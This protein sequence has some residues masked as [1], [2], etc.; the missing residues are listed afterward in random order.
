MAIEAR[1]KKGDNALKNKD[2]L[3]A[4]QEFTAA[5]KEN[6]ESFAPFL[7][8]SSAYQKLSNYEKAKEDISTAFTI[9]NQRGKRTEIGLCYFRLGLIYYLEKKFKMAL[10]Q[11]EKATEYDCQEKTLAMWKNKA[12]YDVKKHPEEEEDDLVGDLE[13]D[14]DYNETAAED[15]KT[16]HSTPINVPEGKSAP[17]TVPKPKVD[18]SDKPSTSIDVINKLA[19]LNIKIREDWYQSNDEVIITIYAK[20]VKEEKLKVDFEK[21]A[22]SIS[23]PSG[24]NS[25]YNY[26]LDPLFD[27]IDPE[28]SKYKIFS[29][30][31]EIQLKKKE[32][33]K[34][35]SLEAE[36]EEIG[37]KQDQDE[38]TP[39][40]PSSSKKKVNWNKFKVDDDDNEPSSTNSFFEKIFKD[41]DE[42]SRRAM[43]KSYVQ[44][45]GTVLTTNWDEAKDKEFETQPPDGMVAKK[46]RQ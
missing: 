45:N 31:L 41:V 15:L 27:E 28:Q 46:W 22:V 42:D 2:Y 33:K 11:F 10:G 7:K 5:I 4:I 43:M 32:A 12:E 1:I 18:L 16:P 25:E 29:T 3:G 40:Y 23:F 39:E 34:W 19:P 17:L 8:R 20:G 26:H 30:K 24:S 44:S 37:N 36:L 9:A 38:S 35:S 21:R 6:P 13:I 14:D